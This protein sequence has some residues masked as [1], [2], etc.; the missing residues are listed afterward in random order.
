ME[1]AFG[2][3]IG[4]ELV[5]ESSLAKWEFAFGRSNDGGFSRYRFWC[6]LS[7]I[8]SFSSH[9]SMKCSFNTVRVTGKNTGRVTRVL[10]EAGIASEVL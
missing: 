6:L 4:A 10:P 3:G 9:S 5:Q 8:I 7:H 1:R 2:V